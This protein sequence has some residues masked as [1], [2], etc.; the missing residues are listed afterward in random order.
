MTEQKRCPE[1]GKETALD[2]ALRGLCPRCLL[3]LG[4]GGHPEDHRRIGSYDVL[5]EVGHPVKEW[6]HSEGSRYIVR[7]IYSIE[8][9]GK[10]ETMAAKDLALQVDYTTQIWDS[11]SDLATVTFS[12]RSHYRYTHGD[13][14]GHIS[15]A[16]QVTTLFRPDLFDL[17]KHFRVIRL[18][19]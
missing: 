15:H 3:V 11:V 8:Q 17:S 9:H 10:Y 1:C 16:D 13:F 4:L 6:P 14:M 19:Q 18:T 7:I 5:R 12:G 2:E